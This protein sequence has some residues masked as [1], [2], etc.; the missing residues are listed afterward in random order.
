MTQHANMPARRSAVER[1]RSVLKALT[2]KQAL[3]IEEDLPAGL[4]REIVHGCLRELR[5]LQ[6]ILGELCE[7]APETWTRSLLLTGLYQLFHT[8]QED[9][10]VVH[11]CVELASKRRRMTGLVNGVLRSAIR[12]KDALLAGLAAQPADIRHSIPAPLAKRWLARFDEQ[13][14]ETMGTWNRQHPATI[15]RIVEPGLLDHWNELK[16]DAE[17][18][19]ETTR[20]MKLTRPGPVP[21]LPGFKKGHFYIQDPSTAIAPALLEAR[22]GERVWDACAAPGGKT[23]MLAES[24][25]GQGTLIASDPHG[26]R[27]GRVHENLRRM[28]QGWV[29]V[30]KVDA[31]ELPADTEPFDAILLDVPCSNTGVLAR[32]PEARWRFSE[33]A[34]Q[35]LVTLQSELLAA[36]WTHLKPGG[37]IVYSTCSIEAEETKDL[38]RAFAEN[39]PGATLHEQVLRLPGL[40]RT[41]GAFAARLT[42]S[43][44][45]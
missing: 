43:R 36:A 9:A 31:R 13:T 44:G 29:T 25:D 32:R 12:D 40:E 41:D 35:H 37:R 4:E 17:P 39:T 24:M 18:L 30:E 38:V 27:L 26:E 34:L 23:I 8:V 1:L 2:E 15:A 6:W 16:V 14:I 11:S 5:G 28:Q 45:E 22:P 21:K 20:W 3:A 42:K 19:F 10:V 7:R 33:K